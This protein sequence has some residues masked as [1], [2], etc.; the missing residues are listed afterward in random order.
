M[1]AGCSGAS[2]IE[3]VRN[4][5][6]ADPALDWM[7]GSWTTGEQAPGTWTEEHWTSPAGD[8]LMLG[9][10]RTIAGGRMTFFEYLRI[11]KREDGVFYI[12]CPQGR[13]AGEGTAFK[14]TESSQRTA[15][16][17]NPAHDFPTRIIY[18]LDERTRLHARIEGNQDGK[19]AA[20]EWVMQPLHSRH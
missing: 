2:K 17:E 1:L 16:F 18:T 19:P 3:S 13:A 6:A 8:G 14:L 10:S 15:I 7:A 11:E 9:M 4:S 20:S 5:N 12:A